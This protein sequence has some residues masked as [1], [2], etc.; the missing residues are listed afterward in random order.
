[1]LIDEPRGEPES[2]RRGFA[3]LD[4]M[5]ADDGAI[6]ER[7]H[8]SAL[9]ELAAG[10]ALDRA[11]AYALLADWQG[12]RGFFFPAVPQAEVARTEAVTGWAMAWLDEFLGRAKSERLN[13]KRIDWVAWLRYETGIDG[14][15]ARGFVRRWCELRGVPEN[16][17]SRVAWLTLGLFIA[18]LAIAVPGFVMPWAY[19]P[20]AF[21][22][23][24][25]TLIYL[26][27]ISA[28]ARF[29]F[30]GQIAV[31]KNPGLLKFFGGMA[32]VMGGFVGAHH[33]GWARI[34]AGVAAIVFAAWGAQVM[35]RSGVARQSS[36]STVFWFGEKA[37]RA[38][39]A[40]FS[41]GVV[42][43][44]LLLSGEVAATW[45]P[46]FYWP[47]F[48]FL[49]IPVAGEEWRDPRFSLLRQ[50]IEAGEGE[51][52]RRL[53]ARGAHP[54]LKWVGGLTPLMRAVE[55]GNRELVELLLS[56]GAD[57][58]LRCGTRETVLE[59]ARI[60]GNPEITAQ[61]EDAISARARRCA[62]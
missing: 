45:W 56:A 58:T 38:A 31:F 34:Y 13:L 57:P 39:S 36:R 33:W 12:E 28:H 18:G 32:V 49:P 23:A 60:A 59:I 30:P 41:Y 44:G 54:D 19:A 8:E 55:Q 11:S 17:P 16:D 40:F 48:M 1:M 51:V 50:A 47:A 42:V 6:G 25:I 35:R 53:I 2:R 7:T 37:R 29:P 15:T 22:P 5:R 43:G 3:L 27:V 4:R 62:I 26:F 14:A 20:L 52:V 46:L 24:V 10:L 21:L 9:A 61:I